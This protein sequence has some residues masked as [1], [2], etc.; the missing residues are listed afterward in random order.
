MRS[1][2]CWVCEIYVRVL[3]AEYGREGWRRDTNSVMW[4][5][6]FGREEFAHPFERYTACALLKETLKML[7]ARQL[8][9]G[10]TI[11][12]IHGPMS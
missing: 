4:N 5:R 6:Q 9:V 12:V 10:H 3:S 2:G 7:S 8:V 1:C 11:Q